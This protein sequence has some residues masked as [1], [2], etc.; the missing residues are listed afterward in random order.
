MSCK[1]LFQSTAKARPFSVVRSA[2]TELNTGHSHLTPPEMSFCRF[3][4]QGWEERFK[5]QKLTQSLMERSH[6]SQ[7]IVDIP[8]GGDGA[9]CF[10]QTSS[11]TD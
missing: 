3:G 7:G 6:A 9:W 1:Y 11:G 10:K 8:A 2:W 4:L 5:G